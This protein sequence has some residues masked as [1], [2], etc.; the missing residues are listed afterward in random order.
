MPDSIAADC[1]L[2]PD[3]R[4]RAGAAEGRGRVLLTGATGFLGAQLLCALL[5]QTEAEV[6]CLVRGANDADAERR[7]LERLAHV[8]PQARSAAARVSV[9]RG[10]LGQARLGL[11]DAAYADACASVDEI[12][13]CAAQVDWAA[14]YKALRRANVLP[15]HGLLRLAAEQRGKRLHFLSSAAVCY[16]VPGS[17]P[18]TEAECGAAPVERLRLPYA[19]SKWVGERL[20]EEACRRGLS[21]TVIRPSIVVGDSRSGASNE[22]DIVSRML[23]ACID[24]RLAPDLDLVLDYCPVDFVA[25]ATVALAR[26]PHAGLRAFH[27]LNPGP[28]R[29]TELVLW[30]NLYGY[31]LRLAPHAQWLARLA[32]RIREPRHPLRPLRNF[33]LDRRDDLDGLTLFE[34]YEDGR[35]TRPCDRATLRRLGASGLAC[36]PLSA[37]L[38]ERYVETMIASG[39]LPAPPRPRARRSVAN[40]FDRLTFE[41][42]LRAALGDGSIRVAGVERL[43]GEFRHGLTSALAGWKYGTDIGLRKYS[44]TLETPRG[45]ARR[46]GL[47]VKVKPF[48][49]E[50]RGAIV[51]AAE[52]CGERLARAFARTAEIP[53]FSGSARRE[54]AVYAQTDSRFTRHAPLCYGVAPQPDARPVL[55]LEDLGG[56]ELLDSV[57]RPQDWRAG[58]IEAAV[59]GMAQVHAVWYGR[60][61]E[62]LREP[63]LGGG[64]SRRSMLAAR[65]LWDALSE[66]ARPRFAAWAG[67]RLGALSQSWLDTLDDWWPELER[68]RRTLI[69]N[70]LNPRNLAFRS[71]PRGPR[72]CAFDW[73]LATLG[74]P[75]RDLAELLCFVLAPGHAGEQAARYLELHRAELERA[76]GRSIERAA[77]REGFGFALRDLLLT[78]LPMYALMHR[79]RRQ[80]FLP[81]VVA[82]WDA[83]QRWH[84]AAA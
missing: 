81:R 2:A 35:A 82:A 67:P 24:M 23:K 62:L 47:V 15:L 69:H 64:H 50:L 77:W 49:E 39:F 72:L 46:L 17:G 19:R 25:R 45:A 5:E 66:H 10:D 59:S 60:E 37:D 21:A 41:P 14:S 54:P 6:L 65:E 28:V 68:Q 57:E 31:E 30:L 53:G 26:P 36:P 18:L 84:A 7:L 80:E 3:I 73:E 11:S 38:I 4:P 8:S 12:Y 71:T 52:V 76:S 44:L 63:W 48:E 56:A 78:R 13:H 40:G 70:D 22:S 58:H 55:L 42:L 74:P 16:L 75:Q 27:L 79:F 20:V 33:F 1:E 9:V 61:A 34:T 32:E 43:G 83:L 51:A 29:W